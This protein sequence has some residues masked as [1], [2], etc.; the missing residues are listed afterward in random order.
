MCLSLGILPSNRGRLQEA[1]PTTKTSKTKQLLLEQ[2]YMYGKPVLQRMAGATALL[3]PGC[4][5][6]LARQ[7]KLRGGEGDVEEGGGAGGGRQGCPPP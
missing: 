7:A 3:P 1:L 4:I 6:Q 5:Q 2:G